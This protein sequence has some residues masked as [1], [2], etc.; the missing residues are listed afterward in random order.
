MT[1]GGTS[2]TI[3]GQSAF[4]DY[5]SPT[6]INVEA[7][8]DTVTGPVQVAVTTAQGTATATVVAEAVMPAVFTSGVYA[9]AVRPSDSTVINGTGTIAS[10]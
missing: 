5:V 9:V 3:N 1:F 4:V 10:A 7:P 2:V 8:A 6:Q